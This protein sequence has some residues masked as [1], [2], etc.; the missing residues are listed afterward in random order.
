MNHDHPESQLVT[1]DDHEQDCGN[2]V[3]TYVYHLTSEELAASKARRRLA[4][5]SFRHDA[6]NGTL[7]LEWP[8]GEVQAFR[9]KP[10]RYLVVEPDEETGSVKPVLRRGCPTFLY[11]CREERE[12]R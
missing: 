8:D 7:R 1:T 2:S 3:T 11:L 4:S 10:A 9:D 5:C 12:G 6:Q